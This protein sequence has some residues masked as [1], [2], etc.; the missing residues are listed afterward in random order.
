[1]AS[2]NVV[3][4]LSAEAQSVKPIV[5]S[6]SATLEAKVAR[7]Q[8]LDQAKAEAVQE[9]EHTEGLIF[10]LLAQTSMLLG[11]PAPQAP[12][13]LSFEPERDSEPRR[14]RQT[15]TLVAAI[16]ELL[17]RHGALKVTELEG[18]LQGQGR[19]T[20]YGSIYATL[21]KGKDRFEKVDAGTFR[22]KSRG[23]HR[24]A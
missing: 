6:L 1:M 11:K 10:S 17:E 9:L 4:A 23:R 19:R 15:G 13:R 14:P 16:E 8:E 7:I 22:L 2:T 24:A 20:P 12:Q 21:S 3:E 18:Y 5:E